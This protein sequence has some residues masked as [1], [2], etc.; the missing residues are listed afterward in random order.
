MISNDIANNLHAI[1]ERVEAAARKSG[2]NPDDIKLVAVSKTKPPELVRQAIDA[3]AAILGENYIQEAREKIE[4][5]GRE[6]A[7]HF[8]GHLQSNKAKY[9]AG[10]FD[11]I[12]SVDSFRLAEA[13]SK[14][15]A[16]QNKTQA[17]LIQV[18]TSG[19]TTKS[20]AAAAETRALIN[21]IAPLPHI[22]IKGLMTMPPWSDDPEDARPYF[23]Q[24]RTLR[25]ELTG[26][27]PETVSLTELSMGMSTDFEVAIEEGATLVRV[28]TSIFGARK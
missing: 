28:G 17:I 8:I 7:W 16:K 24:L 9:A 20:G 4:L 23:I 10:L 6:V 5:L 13:L 27:V 18:N 11:L 21:E 2:R 19:E 26:T 14:A 22:A 12:H 3:G 15:A 25:D 1:Q